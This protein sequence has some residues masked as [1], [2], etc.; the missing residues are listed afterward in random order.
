MNK[1]FFIIL[2][3]IITII[4]QPLDTSV[5]YLANYIIS[6]DFVSIKSSIDDLSAV[7]SLYKVS[8]NYHKGNTAEAILT[9]TFAAL[10]FYELPIQVPIIG[11]KI[12]LPLVKVDRILFERK[13]DA[14]PKYLFFDSPQNKFGDM[15][16]IAHFFGSAYFSNTVTIFKLSKFM[17][18]FVE[19]FEAAFKVDGFLDY[20]DMKVNNLGELFG[21]ALRENPDLMPSQVLKLYNLFYYRQ[22]N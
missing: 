15:D 18:I 20:R 6:D 3:Q 17:G 13:I 22:T 11:L 8:L 14:L 9:V 7:D 5:S 16:K 19:F 4:A 21:L 10:A 1:F 2:F 12:N